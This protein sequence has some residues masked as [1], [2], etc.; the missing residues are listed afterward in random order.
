MHEGNDRCPLTMYLPDLG[1]LY[2][3]INIADRSMI[4]HDMA[5]IIDELPICRRGSRNES[6]DKKIKR[7]RFPWV[8]IQNKRCASSNEEQN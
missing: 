2:T 4:F 3:S 7:C 5:R 8:A 6:R 1:I